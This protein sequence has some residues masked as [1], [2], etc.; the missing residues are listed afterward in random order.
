MIEMM[1]G[2]FIS[3]LVTIWHSRFFDFSKQKAYAIICST[4]LDTLSNEF[5]SG[6]YC[7]HRKDETIHRLYE[8]SIMLNTQGH[9]QAL[10]TVCELQ[11]ILTDCHGR[12]ILPGQTMH[13][14]IQEMANHM[15]CN[16]IAIVFGVKVARWYAK[17]KI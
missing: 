10:E 13:M 1:I 16:P 9:F 11:R 17:H 3:I 14:D 7:V 15:R 5:G 2:T 12:K 6:V 4:K 8:I